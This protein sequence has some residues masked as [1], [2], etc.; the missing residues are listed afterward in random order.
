MSMEW[1]LMILQ[2][3]FASPQDRLRLRLPQAY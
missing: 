1:E 3:F 2:L